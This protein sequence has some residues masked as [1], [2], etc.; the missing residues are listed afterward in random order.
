MLQLSHL[1]DVLSPNHAQYLLFRLYQY[2]YAY[3]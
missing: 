1:Y 2:K 3:T